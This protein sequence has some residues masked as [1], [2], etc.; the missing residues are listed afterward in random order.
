MALIRDGK[1][2]EGTYG[3]VYKAHA[4]GVSMSPT[5]VI[6]PNDTKFYAV[7]RNLMDLSTSWTGNTRELDMLAHLKGHPFIVDLVDVSFGDPFGHA[8]PMTPVN[9]QTKQ[10]KEDKIHFV[11]EYLPKSGAKFFADKLQCTPLVAKILAAQL[12]LG[13]EYI[14]AHNITHRDLKPANLLVSTEVKGTPRLKICDFGMSAILCRGA[15]STPGVATSWYRGP[16]VCAGSTIYTQ[17]SD[18][19]SVGAII[20]ELFGPR[21]Y[22]YAIEDNDVAAFNAILGKFPTRPSPDII[23]K[24]QSTSNRKMTIT[25]AASPIRRSSY[26]EQLQMIPE[27]L[28]EFK[29]TSGTV[30]QL[31]EV[32]T[33]L[34]QL[35][36]DRRWNATR[37]LDHPFFDYLRDYINSVRKM[38]PP[39]PAPLPTLRI[40]GCMERKWA[41]AVAFAIYNNR[42]S[43]DW[44]RH[45]LLFH[46]IAMFDRYL[47]W[48]HTPGAPVALGAMET[49]HTGRLH[50]RA[51]TELRFWVCL[52]LVHKYFATMSYPVDW[53]VFAPAVYT[54]DTQER[55]AEQFEIVLIK[56][57]SEG[58]RIYRDTLL[59]IADQFPQ[60]PI[61]EE[62]VRELLLAYGQCTGWGEGSV[63]ALYRKIMKVE[64]PSVA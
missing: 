47:V 2:G 42:T 34:L 53:K 35:D 13:V 54:G 40:I 64:P 30:E 56:E 50:S 29:Q 3:V 15:P 28:A 36:P 8:C 46:A 21:A 5:G 58:Y 59:E 18:N 14:H 1:I 25:A 26:I 62:L 57:V 39:V 38:Y 27:Y 63:R 60:R 10:M 61:T 7:K 37:A 43:I 49:S 19:W 41:I 20:Y 44:Y 4:P 32:I 9:E 55:I 17:A 22:L 11:M 31:V 23:A 12:L 52:Y 6:S 48:A 16:E 51:E 24:L 45:R 33:G